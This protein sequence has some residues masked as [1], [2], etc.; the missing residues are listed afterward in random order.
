MAAS[1]FLG[2]DIGTSGVRATVINAAGQTQAWRR[3]DFTGLSLPGEQDAQIWWAAL[4]TLLT[5][6]ATEGL[7]PQIAAIGVDATSGTVLAVD[8]DNQPV[9]PALMYND[10]RASAEAM[11]VAAIAPHQSAAHGAGSGLA[12]YLYLRTHATAVDWVSQ[13]D[14]V[15]RR[16][17][18]EK[19]HSDQHNM[20]KWGWDPVS[21]TWPSWL[22][23]LDIDSATLPQVHVP[24]TPI[25]QIDPLLAARF[26]LNPDCRL[27]AA[28]TDSN[29]AFIATGAHRFGE[30]VTSLGS[31]LVTKVLS[32]TPVFAPEYGVY[33]HALG[34]LWLVGGS[35]NSGG[36]VLKQHFCPGE[37]Q[38]L[39]AR[40]NPH[41]RTCLDYYPLPDVGERFPINDATLAP[42]LT[43]RPNDDLRFF[44]AML[45]GMARIE[46]R[47]YRLLE[48]LGAPYPHTLRS[49]GGGAHN[50]AWSEIRRQMLGVE[51]HA[52]EQEEAAYGSACLAR[53]GFEQR[54]LGG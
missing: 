28:T 21:R 43:P 33:S 9:A 34:D 46:R 12:K 48:R 37:I 8:A 54:S 36:A 45:E 29:A 10:R 32:K 30:A 41:R 26:S 2:I 52:A 35:S 18:A 47:A 53:D 16:L 15:L 22:A 44:Q 1:L 24:G 31:T 19:G 25:G 49:A 39:S 11:R 5:D 4:D 14:W 17:G 6:L 13:A 38:T 20:L 27:G 3:Q 51:L 40:V 23:A 7:G 50:K 42:R